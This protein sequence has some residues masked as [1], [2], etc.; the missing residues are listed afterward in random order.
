MIS[1]RDR[2]RELRKEII[3]DAALSLFTS[4][5]YKSVTVQDIAKA[6]EY[7]KGTLY[8]YF[9]S[10]EDI[11]IYIME[12]GIDELC[13]EIEARCYPDTDPMA[14]I[15]TYMLLQYNYYVKYS[16]MIFSLLRQRLEGT[17]TRERLKEVWRIR[18]KKYELLAG[19]IERGV[20]QG[21]FISADSQKLARIL[22]N[23]VRGFSMES[24][25]NK[26]QGVEI[27]PDFNLIK[28]VISSGIVNLREGELSEPGD[29]SC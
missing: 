15:Y 19:I 6:A 8:Q 1:R 20:N 14:A 4:E 13:R 24:L 12:R 28:Q 29:G 27:E 10:K 9:E 22:H 23:I 11:L 16:H 25:E 21:I 3:A 5:S 26:G 2:E 7:G 18:N 17:L